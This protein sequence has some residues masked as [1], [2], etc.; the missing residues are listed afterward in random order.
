MYIGCSAS[1]LA[2]AGLSFK[3]KQRSILLALGK[4]KIA[5]SGS[6]LFTESV[7]MV[8]VPHFHETKFRNT[9]LSGIF[10]N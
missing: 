1:S 9:T 2:I 8:A 7:N 4:T 6:E 3:N 5:V 10:L